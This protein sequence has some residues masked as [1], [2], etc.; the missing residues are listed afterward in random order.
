MVV[1]GTGNITV[2]VTN[3]TVAAAAKPAA[4]TTSSALS[5]FVTLIA[6]AKA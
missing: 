4:T 5:G 1:A 3:S 6:A 2:A